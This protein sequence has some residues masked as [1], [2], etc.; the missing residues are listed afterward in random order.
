M[1]IYTVDKQAFVR[2]ILYPEEKDM[3]NLITSAGNEKFHHYGFDDLGMPII[4]CDYKP[5][6]SDLFGI[7]WIDKYLEA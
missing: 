4:G 1:G 7:K 5:M 6:D 2:G 3:T